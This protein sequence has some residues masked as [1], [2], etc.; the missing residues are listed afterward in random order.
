MELRHLK[1]FVTVAEEHSFS[2]AARRLNIAQPPLSYQINMLEQ[3]LN[4][5]L[6][7]RNTR[8][9]ELTMA[10]KYFYEQSLKILQSVQFSC[11]QTQKIANNEIGNLTIS[12]SSNGI[13]YSL[14]K[15]VKK[16]RHEYPLV[17]LNLM[18]L[19]TSDQLDRIKQNFLQIGIVCG[20]PNLPEIQSA[21]LFEEK[22][23]IVLPKNHPLAKINTSI[24]LDDLQEDFFIL[25]QKSA[26]EYY[27]NVVES[28]FINANFKPNV[29]QKV[30]ELDTALSLVKSGLG[31]TIVPESIKNFRFNGIVF[32]PINNTNEKLITSV[33]WN[34][35]NKNSLVKLFVD[36]L[37]DL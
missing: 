31:I 37:R 17:N 32:K 33:I 11:E 35:N 36:S 3:E 25:T 29:I 30:C 10:G 28:I 7:N 23:L 26:G 5:K 6:F 16:F 27:Y 1:Y 14:P 21:F 13:F 2:K 34:K 4:L 12:F 19:N 22:F 20:T 18:Q 8:P 15:V 24:N 9:I